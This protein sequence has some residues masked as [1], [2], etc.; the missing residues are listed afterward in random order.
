MKA[1]FMIAGTWTLLTV[2]AALEL[3]SDPRLF[4][5]VSVL[6]IIGLAAL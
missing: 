5:Q 4:A 3:P 2:A 6:V 1:T